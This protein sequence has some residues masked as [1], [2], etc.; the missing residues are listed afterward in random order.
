MSGVWSAPR[1]LAP[2]SVGEVDKRGQEGIRRGALSRSANK[3]SKE[4]ILAIF[5][6]DATHSIADAP[7]ITFLF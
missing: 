4:V 5:E 2:N 7:S 1:T 6:A 3:D